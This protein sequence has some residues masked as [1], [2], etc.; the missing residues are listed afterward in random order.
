MKARK[1]SF[2]HSEYVNALRCQLPSRAF[3]AAPQKL[4]MVLGH[5]I[6]VLASYLGIRYSPFIAY[7]ALLSLVIAH[8][9]ICIAFLAHELSHNAI[10]R[11]RSIRYPLEVLLWGLN[12]IPATMWQ[13]LHNHSHHIQGNTIRDP[14]RYFVKS[15]L[16]PPG[17]PVRRWYAKLCFPHRSN[18]MWNPL[19]WFHFIT[20]IARHLIAFCYPG[21]RIPS[22]VTHKP[23]YTRP[24]RF[25]ILIELVCIALLQYAIYEIVGARWQS[26]IWASPIALLFTSVFI[27][28][29][30]WTNHYLHG[31]REIHDPVGSSTSVIVH[32]F[33]DILHCHFSYH[34]EH[35]IFPTM[36]SDYYPLVSD[37]L[38]ER[39]PDR[40]HRLPIREALR[41]V[42]QN[43]QYID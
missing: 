12:A 33:F 9:F 17:S 38:S 4:W 5:L 14:D 43:E 35:H 29:Y 24:Q 13:R 37:L 28:A 39:Y 23:A 10:I 41:Q 2:P 36:N 40:Y 19:V 31:L 27:M 42:F 26:F 8:S 6:I 11:N 1:E 16:Q 30:I 20:Y 18:P 25:R 32:P 22:I 15:E 21:N 7:D 34:T 3:A